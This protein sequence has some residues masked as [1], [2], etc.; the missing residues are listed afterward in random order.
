MSIS[1][2]FTKTISSAHGSRDGSERPIIADALRRAA[3]SPPGFHPDPRLGVFETILIV[4]DRPIELDA[5]LERIGRSV[6]ALYGMKPPRGLADEVLAS[7]RGGGL[8]RL[9]LTVEPTRDG[10][11]RSSI[12]VA[13][14]E[15]DDVFPTGPFATALRSLP[16]ERGWGDHKYADREMPAREEASAGP[17]TAPL[18]VR[19]DDE[20]LEAARAN[21]FAVRAGILVTPPL[22]G[23]ILPG[24]TRAAV[25]EEAAKIGVELRR[26]RLTLE[27][28]HG[29]EEVFLTGSLR[30]VEP[31]RAI[32]DTEIA[33][34][35]PLTTALAAEL[36]RRWFGGAS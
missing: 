29:A 3:P 11:L 34:E 5:H 13:G 23:S 21:V 6:R 17:G 9:R 1:S 33:A 4:E 8:G 16:V 14:F 2:V 27:D 35:G 19:G 25:I 36:R 22:E 24:V 12:V 32:D 28:L 15:P 7:S 20:V 31:V 18:L 30:G 10:G 26:Q